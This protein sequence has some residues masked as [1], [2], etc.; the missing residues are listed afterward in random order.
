[1]MIRNLAINVGS[2]KHV[3]APRY[4]EMVKTKIEHSPNPEPAQTVQQAK[5]KA[6]L[7]ISW[8]TKKKG[9]LLNSK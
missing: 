9:V 8:E 4:C 2:D 3:E 5:S 6:G 7:L 1:M